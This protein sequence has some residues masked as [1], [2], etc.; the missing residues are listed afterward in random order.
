MEAGQIAIEVQTIILALLRGEKRLAL[1][2]LRSL[3]T[4]DEYRA[5]K[6]CGGAVTRIKAEFGRISGEPAYPADFSGEDRLHWDGTIGH[7][8]EA[9]GVGPLIDDMRQAAGGKRNILYFLVAEKGKRS[10]RWDLLLLRKEE[11]KRQREKADHR[12]GGRQL[13]K[14]LREII[15]GDMLK[16]ME[17]GWVIRLRKE[18][19]T[20]LD[21]LTSGKN[22]MTEE[23]ELRLRTIRTQ[24]KRFERGELN[25]QG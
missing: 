18:Q 14:R 1:A 11:A 16:N 12:E 7:Y 21:Q 20:L 17:P 13:M 23:I 22:R 10:S 8:V 9:I 24:L 25:G 2:L 19:E 15:Q 4:Q 3:V 5:A 6:R